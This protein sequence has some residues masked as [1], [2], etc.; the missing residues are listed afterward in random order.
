MNSLLDKTTYEE[1]KQR[2]GSLSSQ[3]KRQWG[4]M[5]VAQMM[6]HCK[7]AFEVPL[8][9]KVYPRLLMGRMMGWIMKSKMYDDSQFGKNL[10]TPADFVVK[11]QR[12]FDSEKQELAGLV[13]KFYTA[14]SQN[15]GNHPHPFFGTFTKDQW[16]R[17]MYKHLDHHLRQFG[18]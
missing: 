13:D 9:D 10:P 7:K 18:V 4:K 1:I 16:G 2:I 11:D 3:S 8:S 15:I 17:F 5:E 14:G 6:A 12:N